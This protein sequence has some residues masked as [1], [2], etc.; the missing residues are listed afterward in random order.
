MINKIVLDIRS[1]HLFLVNQLDT[2]KWGLI[3]HVVGHVAKAF[4]SQKTSGQKIGIPIW[5]CPQ[6]SEK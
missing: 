1:K 4:G 3:L 5:L 2:V 6:A